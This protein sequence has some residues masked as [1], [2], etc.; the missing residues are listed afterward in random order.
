MAAIPVENHGN[1]LFAKR[2]KNHSTLACNCESRKVCKSMTTATN[3]KSGE[4]QED[5]SISR[6]TRVAPRIKS[7]PKIRQLYWCDFWSDAMLPEMW[8][9]RPVIVLSH[10]NTLHGP[11]LIVPTS[12]DPGN[13][14]DRWACKLPRINGCRESWAICNQ[15][16]TVS[17]SRLSQFAGRIPLL[18]RQA[19]N[20]V[21]ALVLKWIPSLQTA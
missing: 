2:S 4:N 11:C 9:T 19:F 18:D 5:D 6:P 13:V 15:P 17:V 12:T 8:K 1:W 10:K 21:H 16:T 14:N 3:E 20:E 7:A